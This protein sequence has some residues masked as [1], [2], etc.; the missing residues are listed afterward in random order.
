MLRRSATRNDDTNPEHAPRKRGNVFPTR[1]FARRTSLLLAARLLFITAAGFPLAYAQHGHGGGSAPHMSA[2][3]SSAPHMSAPH[4]MQSAPRQSA[5]Q[6]RSAP[7]AY[8]G[9]PAPGYAPRPAPY[10]PAPMNRYTPSPAM[11]QPRPAYTPGM[12]SPYASNQGPRNTYAAPPARP[13]QQHL[14]GWLQ[15]HQGQSFA[16]QE[17]SLRQEPGFNRL[18]PQQQQRLVDQLHRLNAMPPEQRQRT[19]GR[20]ENMERLSPDRRQAVRNSA[21]ELSNMDPARRQQVRGAFRSLRDLPPGQRE[22]VLNSP[23]Y[24]SQYSDHERQ[25]LGNLLSVEPYQPR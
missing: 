4:P 22:Q 15:N 8:S 1:V 2:P 6:Y 24:R 25:V 9:R 7:P 11:Q 13:G 18:P 5:P 17:N 16:S 12:T 20:V 14:G 21:Q 3:H 10:Q 23:Q 19:L